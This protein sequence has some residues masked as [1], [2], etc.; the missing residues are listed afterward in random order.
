MKPA[1]LF[2]VNSLFNLNPPIRAWRMN[3][4]FLFLVVAAIGDNVC[5]VSRAMSRTLALLP[6]C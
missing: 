4:A 1:R 3:R 2:I 5:I 6:V